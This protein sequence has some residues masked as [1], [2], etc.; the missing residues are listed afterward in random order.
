MAAAAMQ[1]G[2][3]SERALMCM[4]G[5]SADLDKGDRACA[6][7]KVTRTCCCCP[8]NTVEMKGL[9]LLPMPVGHPPCP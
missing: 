8:S 9:L 2:G 7:P 1:V 5:G 3:S 6:S 4:T